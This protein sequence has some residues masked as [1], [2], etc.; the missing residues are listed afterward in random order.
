[1]KDF[2]EDLGKRIGETAENMTN[3]AGEAIEIQRL[4]SQIRG[5]ARENAVNMIDLGKIVYEHYKAGEEVEEAARGYCDA[6]KEREK[7]IAQYEKEISKIRGA[8]E[9]PNCGKLI[10]T[11][12]SFCPYCGEKVVEEE[13]TEEQTQEQADATE[14]AVNE[15][16]Q[17]MENETSGG[18]EEA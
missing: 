2:W 1:M 16:A 15:A 11:G 9:C 14:D 5:M 3:K 17:K 18:S 7:S 13:E 6:I 8:H 12:M 4:K 10:Q